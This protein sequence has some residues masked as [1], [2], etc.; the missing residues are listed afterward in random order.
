MLAIASSRSANFFSTQGGA[1][2]VD[3][4]LKSKLQADGFGEGAEASTRGA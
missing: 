3:L 1:C 2:S 4:L